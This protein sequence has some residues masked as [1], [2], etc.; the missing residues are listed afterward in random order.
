[1]KEKQTFFLFIKEWESRSILKAVFLVFFLTAPFIFV[2]ASEN[3]GAST[4]IVQNTMQTGQ[5]AEQTGKT[6]TG[7]VSDADG[8]PMPGVT[9]IVKGTSMGAVTD[10][11]G[12]YSIKV[13]NENDILVFSFIGMA[14]QEI[15]VSGKSQIVVTLVSSTEVLEDVV[16]VG[17]GVQKKESVVGAITQAKGEDLLKAGG[18][19]NVGEAL[20]GR[21]P[22]VTTIYSSGLPGESDP[23]IFIRGQSSWNGSGQPLI[24]VDGIER[25]MSDI[26]LNEIDQISVLKDASATAVFGVKGANGVIL[27]TTKRGKT[28][29]AQL[30]ISANSTIKMYSK[31]PNKLNSFDAVMVGNESIMREV[32][33]Q[34]TSW[35][36]YV[37][38][39]I[40]DKY[41]NPASIEESY[42][43]PNIDWTDVILKDH[44]VDQRVNLSVRGGS[45]FAKY[46]GSL[47]YQ[48]VSDLFKGSSYPNGKGYMGEYKYNR[49]NY[50]SNLDFNITKTT[51]FSVNLSGFFGIQEKPYE[52]LRMALNSIYELAPSIYTP[53]YPDGYYGRHPSGEWNFN[54]PVVNLTN[55]GNNT[56]NK[57]QINSDFELKQKL[58]F[59]TKGLSLKGKLSYDNDM[60]SRQRIF[61]GTI[62]NIENVIY[63][64]YD[65]D[66]NEIIF[67]PPGRNDFDFV[68]Q[69]W[70][71]E[72][73][74]VQDN[75][76]MR[77]LNYEISLNYNR[78][79]SQKH[80]VSALFL[81]KRE[82]FAIGNMFPRFREDWVGRVTYNYD[83]RYF[84]DVNGA[85]NGSEKFGPGYRFDLF[86]SVALGWMVS[87][88]AFMDG[89]DWMDKFKIRGSYGLVGDDNF[90]GRWKYQ[91]QWGSGGFAYLVP[92]NFTSKSPY[93]WYK[94][95]VVGNP[96]LQWE[97]A[98]K[99]NIGME[100]SLLKNMFSLDFDYFMEDRDNILILGSQRSVPDLF[101]TAPPD[102]NSG[103][104]EVRG[105]ELVL[106]FNHKF[107]NGISLWGNFSLTD[108]KDKVIY[109][110]DPELK[111]FYQKA[112]GYP[113]G[114]TRAAIPGNI[115]TSWDDIYMATPRVSDQNYRRPGYYDLVDFDI[116]GAYNSAYDNAP[117][118]YPV[119]PQR[120]WTVTAGTGYKGVN[121][122]VQLYGTQNA[123]RNY[124]TRTF[125][126]QTHLYYEHRLG[127]WSVNNPTG[128]TTL[129]AW[130]LGQAADE[131]LGNLYDASLLRLKTVELSYDIPNKLCK[132]IGVNG[133][134]I[135]A[136]GNNL[137]LWTKL[138][139]DR[140]YNGSNTQ[141]SQYRGDYP[142]MKRFN[143]GLNLKF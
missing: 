35:G 95:A 39:Q 97:T 28:G 82:E 63:R 43:Y 88:E 57:F 49:F 110:E 131:P 90:S 47:S 84:I 33:Y 37:P 103:K 81:M 85:Y 135:F 42:I 111:P 30:N 142:T 55:R 86:P 7:V 138:P 115:L 79:F 58:D 59:I 29:K 45:D 96:N 44:A 14:T 112:E 71:T 13:E 67:S 60:T 102:F 32:M 4:A 22:G 16:V 83:S 48:S 70:T 128:N 62:E 92:S 98:I 51:L 11:D 89:I 107:T 27:I 100:L 94:E 75:T 8:N 133:L 99:S 38:M 6:V 31:L 105:Y 52:D 40:A 140:E 121:L 72:P 109:R 2:Y 17:Y 78:I 125:V 118:G 104:V 141:E 139:D 143:F 132:R 119:R 41:R 69:P 113:I 74:K 10:I 73:T 129:D 23:Q 91:T 137:Y 123:T 15:S 64:M 46:F 20:Q 106:G 24:L 68:V 114:Q 18:V 65:I 56:Y 3:R 36:D 61:D 1:M 124:D 126:K 12:K 66:G 5:N 21:L 120:T 108:A 19:T 53:I 54:N 93:L 80:N 134:R 76:R 9:V 34:P 122:M 50:R 77:R 101:G 116:D 136:N 117:Y 130:S 25:G 87:N 26:D 127:Y